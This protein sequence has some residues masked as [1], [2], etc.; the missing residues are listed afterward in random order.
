MTRMAEISEKFV[1][2]TITHDEARV[3]ATGTA[4]GSTPEK[5]V[6]PSRTNVHHHVRRGQDHH[7][8]RIHEFDGEFL[9]SVSQ[10]V[11][12]AG[13]IMLIGHGKGKT[14][15]LVALVQHLERKHPQTAR[16]VI[17][18]LHADIPAMSEGEILKLARQWFAAH[19]R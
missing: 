12:D 10:A 7:M 16:K 4:P 8:H 18:A 9:E 11:A 19:P 1:V 13:T 14:D 6:P 15:S 2:V 3:W 17:G 5:I